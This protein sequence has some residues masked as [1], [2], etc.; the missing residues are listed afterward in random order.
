MNFDKRISRLLAK[1]L[2]VPLSISCFSFCCVSAMEGENEN[3]KTGKKFIG[4]KHLSTQ[5]QELK[6]VL[7]M[8]D[9]AKKI[10][11]EFETINKQDERK[12]VKEKRQRKD[13]PKTVN[14]CIRKAISSQGSDTHTMIARYRSAD[15]EDKSRFFAQNITPV[16]VKTISNIIQNLRELN[17][18]NPLAK[19][20][21]AYLS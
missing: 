17:E 19:E 21:P 12:E 4:N 8:L 9:R 11:K 2:L 14:Q 16:N 5:E 13:K 1:S 20:S 10:K 7:E 6:K 18:T 3:K 15:F